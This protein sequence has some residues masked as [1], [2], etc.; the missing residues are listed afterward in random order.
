MKSSALKN[1]KGGIGS[2]AV[3]I[4]LGAGFAQCGTKVL[5]IDVDSQGN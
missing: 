5:L 4:S 2:S 1:Q 3:I